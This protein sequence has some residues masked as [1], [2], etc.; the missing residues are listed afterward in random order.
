MLI[1]G[2]N[3]VLNQIFTEVNILYYK[4][5]I[6]NKTEQNK[7]KTNNMINLIIFIYKCNAIDKNKQ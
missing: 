5:K 2:L 3:S 7:L 4:S 1:K 6:L